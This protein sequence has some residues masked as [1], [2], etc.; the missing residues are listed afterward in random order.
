MRPRQAPRDVSGLFTRTTGAATLLMLAVAAV[1][2]VSLSLGA[3]EIPPLEIAAIL[4][5]KLG[6]ALPVNYA[7]GDAALLWS[8]R[9]PRV[10]CGLFVGA[11]LALAGAVLQGL[12]RNPLA[13]PALIGVSSGAALAAVSCLVLGEALMRQVLPGLALFVVPAASFLGGFLMVNLVWRL[14]RLEGRTQVSTMLLAGVALNSLCGA[15][16]GV[17]TFLANDAQLRSI[18]FWS[19]G[20]LGGTTWPMVGVLAAM[21][22]LPSLW[23]V[24]QARALNVLLLGEAEAGHLGVNV[25]SLKRRMILAAALV[26]GVSVSFV[27]MIGFVGLVTPHLIRL[28][29]GA[30]YRRLL[31]CAAWLGAFLLMAADLI[32]RLAVAPAELPIGVVTALLG[33]PFFLWILRKER[34]QL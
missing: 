10:L 7:P 16:I 3:V 17:L 22:I 25:E 24:R 28:W 34:Q 1:G 14:S 15:G 31:P 9:L 5:G 6:V 12:F 27:G 8:I 11:G 18:T 2:V 23:M 26:V 21:T 29:L 32:S 4:A 33:A 30:D 20:S 13:D 19:L